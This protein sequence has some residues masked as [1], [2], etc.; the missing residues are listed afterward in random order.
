[1]RPSRLRAGRSCAAARETAS[2]LSWYLFHVAGAGNLSGGH[3]SHPLPSFRNLERTACDFLPWTLWPRSLFQLLRKRN[4]CSVYFPRSRGIDSV[5][6]L[7][8]AGETS[9]Q[10]AIGTESCQVQ[11]LWNVRSQSTWKL[12]ETYLPC[13]RSKISFTLCRT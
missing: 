10:F 1:M 4:S 12:P 13:I 8:S 2:W 7:C 6:F 11:R 5:V 9:L 3:G